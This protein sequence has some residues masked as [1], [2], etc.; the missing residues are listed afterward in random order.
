VR[1]SADVLDLGTPTD[2]AAHA[3]I[4]GWVTAAAAREAFTA[5]GLD[6]DTLMAA[7]DHA[8]FTPVT[9]P[10]RG[11]VGIGTEII[12]LMSRNVVATLGEVGAATEFV[13]FSSNWNSLLAAVS[14][15]RLLAT[16]SPVDPPSGVAVMIEVARALASQPIRGRAFVFLSVTASSHGLLGLDHYLENPIHPL[17]RT[18]AG[19]HIS[20]FSTRSD[21]S[22]LSI[23]AFTDE[24]LKQLVRTQAAEQFR[25]ATADRDPRRRYVFSWAETLY[26]EK[27][28]PSIFLTSALPRPSEPSPAAATDF[29]VGILDAQLAYHVGRRVATAGNRPDWRPVRAHRVPVAAPQTEPA[30]SRRT[31]R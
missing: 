23:V 22:Q 8:N 2:T 3:P 4:E 21:E 10:L 30:S 20:G 7:A 16:A 15:D 11:S 25:A 6:L 24:A 13:I 5:A 29:S 27:E 17:D 12:P 19:I 1:N 14:A 9:V 31:T 18:R 26:T 28:I